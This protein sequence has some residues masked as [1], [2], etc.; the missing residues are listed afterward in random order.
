MAYSELIKNFAKIREYISQFFITAL[1]A[2]MSTIQKAQ[3]AMITSEE[4]LKAGSV[5]I[6]H[7]DKTPRARMSFSQLTAEVF[8]QIPS[9]MYLRQK[10]LLQMT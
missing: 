2:E 3:E 9:T 5:N 8:R 7:S 4:E 1:K 6:C 10:A